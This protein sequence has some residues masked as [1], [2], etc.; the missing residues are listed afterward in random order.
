MT[1]FSRIT[2]IAYACACTL[3]AACSGVIG[4]P[5]GNPPTSD[6]ASSDG[7]VSDHATVDQI[8]ADRIAGDVR[9]GGDGNGNAIDSST[10]NPARSTFYVSGRDI[11]D[12]CGNKFIARGVN[13]PTLYVDRAGAAVPEIAMTGANIVRIFWYAGNGVA[14]TEAE[15]I[16]GKLEQAGMVSM[17]EMHDSTCAW[18]LDAIKA[19]WTSAAAVALIQRHQHAFWLNIANE[20]SPP[21]AAAYLSKYTELI[22]AIRTAGI[23]VPLV[24]DGGNCGRDSAVLFSTGAALLAADPEHN[25]IFSWH[26]YDALSQA[27]IT[28]VFQRSM[29]LDLPFIVGEYANKSPPGCGAAL[30]Y[31]FMISEAQ[32][33]GIGWLAWS[34][35]DNSAAS[36]WNTDCGEF[37]MTRTFAFSTLE[38]WGLEVAV[39]DTNSIMKTA[40][41]A[42]GLTG[43]CQ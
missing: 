25:L 17:L 11:F 37:D 19:Y 43:L 20:T 36:A 22:Q 23:K 35:G 39:T 41:R 38:R 2:R 30:D 28:Q 18:D 16:I 33:T 14:I 26:F 1:R 7:S 34:W 13:H 21:S 15:P 40:V 9:A 8:T 27:Q 4:N 5:G 31:R 6:A 29:T 24:L 3:L 42:K 10:S 32:R 12:S